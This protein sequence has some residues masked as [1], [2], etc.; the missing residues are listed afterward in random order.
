MA[1]ALAGCL[2]LAVGDVE[3]ADP[4]GDP[5]LRNWDAPVSC[6]HRAVHGDVAWSLDIYAQ[7]QVAY[8]PLE[9]DL[10]AG[11]AKAAMTTVLFPA[12]EAPPSAYWAVTPEGLLTRARLELSDDERPVYTVTAVEA[13]VPQLPRAA[14]TRFA[15]IVREQRPDTPVAE[16]FAASV[17][18]LRETASGL[19]RFSLD[20]ATG[21]SV[22]S[23]KQNL[24]VWERVIRQMESAWA[25]SG[26]YP[27]DLYR[28][29]LEA[30]DELAGIGARLPREVTELLGTAREE[31]DRRFVAATAEDPSGSLRRE[32]TGASADPA[33][34][35]WWWH[36]RPKH[37][38]WE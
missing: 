13:P 16:A 15:E 11:F 17:D 4:D 31:L 27:A 25:P 12:V 35:N 34:V 9:S 30:R 22:W 5:D 33:S 2:G 14:V 38:P 29:R 24:V 32:L 6:E 3:V 23:A 26:W 28:E 7:E 36:R 8:Q 37:T 20:D 18:R 21:S 10:A 1:L 19:A